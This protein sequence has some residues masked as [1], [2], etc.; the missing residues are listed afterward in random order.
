MLLSLLVSLPI[1]VF[2][3]EE[4]DA[5][6]LLEESV[7]RLEMTT[8]ELEAERELRIQWMTLAEEERRLRIETQSFASDL[9]N[10]IVE[11]DERLRETGRLFDEYESAARASEIR[12]AL[13]AGAI[14]IGVGAAGA[15]AAILIIR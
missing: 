9:M 15:I 13:I 2:A 7:N 1:S 11:R 8:N 14:G 10:A 12:T 4:T 5:E 3:A 6:T